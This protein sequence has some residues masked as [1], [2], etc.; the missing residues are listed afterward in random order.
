MTI[1][2]SGAASIGP[3][4]LVLPLRS[5]AACVAMCDALLSIDRAANRLRVFATETDCPRARRMAEERATELAAMDKAM[6]DTLA[7]M[8]GVRDVGP[9]L[10]PNL[11]AKGHR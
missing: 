8:Q 4:P 5:F 2:R 10:A 3:D 11:A 9:L 6:R 1:I 7:Q